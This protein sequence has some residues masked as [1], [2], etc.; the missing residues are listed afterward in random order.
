MGAELS[1]EAMNVVSKM[2]L[3]SGRKFVALALANFADENWSCF[4]SVKKISAWTCLSDKA[5]RDHLDAL[6][7][8]GFIVRKR[9]RR[10]DGTLGVYLYV[11]QRQISPVADFASGENFHSPAAKTTAHNHQSY[12]SIKNT[13]NAGAKG[14]RLPDD[15]EPSQADLDY[16]LNTGWTMEH[17][18]IEATKFRNYWTSKAGKDATKKNWHRTWQ[19]WCLNAFPGRQRQTNRQETYREIGN[20]LLREMGDERS[21]DQIT[22]RAFDGVPADERR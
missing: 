17:V 5:V 11:I 3:P 19:N 21:E 12:P 7:E 18:R 4:P 14:T 20:R 2:Q 22:Y 6:E 13:N 9:D 8:G 10:D 15:W 16:A 1:I